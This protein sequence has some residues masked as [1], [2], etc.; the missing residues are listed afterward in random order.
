VH[1]GGNCYPAVIEAAVRIGDCTPA[2]ALPETPV[3]G[4]CAFDYPIPKANQGPTQ[5]LERTAQAARAKR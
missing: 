3:G 4:A 5:A 1:R 2:L